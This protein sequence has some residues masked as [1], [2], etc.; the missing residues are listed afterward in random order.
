MDIIG[1]EESKYIFC[2]QIECNPFHNRIELVNFCQERN[3]HITAYGSL[4]K[5]TPFIESL[6]IKYNK[7]PQQILLKWAIQ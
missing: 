5:I 2:N 6:G 3:I 4:Y 7:T 1:P